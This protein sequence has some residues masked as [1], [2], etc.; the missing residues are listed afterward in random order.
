MR[1]I[2]ETKA[3]KARELGVVEYLQRKGYKFLYIETVPLASF[4]GY[5]A[6]LDGT[7]FALVEIKNR[8]NASDA[9]PTYMI[10]ASKVRAMLATAKAHQLRALL[11]VRFT[12]G[13]FITRLED[14]EQT[15]EG[16]RYDRNDSRD[17]EECVYI[18]MER[19]R[20]L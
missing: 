20:K 4:D 9:Y 15:G 19:F 1:P 5:M 3:D 17:I 2:Y 12:D 14:N 16:G 8:R 6:R 10:S 11:F 7:P 18:P 13:V